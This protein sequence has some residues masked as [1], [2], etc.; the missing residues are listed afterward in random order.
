MD[1][2]DPR[3]GCKAASASVP[4]GARRKRGQDQANPEGRAG[5]ALQPPRQCCT[6]ATMLIKRRLDSERSLL[7]CVLWS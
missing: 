2:V 4:S 7:H 3:W 1:M 6:R 5:E